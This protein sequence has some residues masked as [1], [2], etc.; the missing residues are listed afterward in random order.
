MPLTK[1][2]SHYDIKTISSSKQSNK[3]SNIINKNKN[4]NK[5]SYNISSYDNINYYERL[6]YTMKK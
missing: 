3:S 2:F 1:S 4:K 6:I 5:N